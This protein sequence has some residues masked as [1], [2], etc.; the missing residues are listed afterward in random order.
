M[1]SSIAAVVISVLIAGAPPVAAQTVVAPFPAS[2]SSA[3]STRRP[4]PATTMAAPLG[5]RLRPSAWTVVAPL[6][7][8][9]PFT[10]ADLFDEG[11]QELRCGRRSDTQAHYLELPLL[12]LRHPA[13]GGVRP[14]VVG[15]PAFALKSSC[16]IEATFGGEN[17]NQ[18]CDQF[19]EEAGGE[20]VKVSTSAPWSA[21]A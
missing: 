19:T 16:E 5:G 6:G 2:A 20:S 15:G 8:G 14:F 18:S 4:S 7:P 21:A 3:A 12:L 1:R 17:I 13:S 9:G 11:R 10:R